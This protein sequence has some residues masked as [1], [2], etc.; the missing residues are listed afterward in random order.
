L[1]ES[2]YLFHL[3]RLDLGENALTDSARTRL[4]ERFGNRVRW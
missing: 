3:A 1:C 4:R 2:P